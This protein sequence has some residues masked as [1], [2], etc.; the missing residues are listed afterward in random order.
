MLSDG[1][2]DNNGNPLIP[3]TYYYRVYGFDKHV[4]DRVNF[5]GSTGSNTRRIVTPVDYALLFT[6]TWLGDSWP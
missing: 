1:I 5:Y 4:N 6:G 3:N 2:L